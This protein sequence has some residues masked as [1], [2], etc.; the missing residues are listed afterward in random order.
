MFPLFD[1]R[2][3]ENVRAVAVKSLGNIDPESN[4]EL[5]FRA[6]RLNKSQYVMI[7]VAAAEGLAKV[8]DLRAVAALEHAA[9]KESDLFVREKFDVAAKQARSLQ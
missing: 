2:V 8:R 9:S 3:H 1:R 7:R 5:L 4:K 6:L